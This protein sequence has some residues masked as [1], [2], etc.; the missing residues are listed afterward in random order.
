MFS[1][2]AD[3]YDLIYSS[4]DY[5]SEARKIREII[6]RCAPGAKSILDVGCGTGEHA[7]Y[8]S[9]PYQV[10]GL[11]LDSQFVDIAKRKVP[12]GD[13][14]VGDM[15]DFTFGKRYDVV[16]CLFSS[17]GYLLSGTEIL[18]A[19]KCFRNHLAA[20]GVVLVEPWILPQKFVSGRVG[21]ETADKPGLKICRMGV[22]VREGDV[23]SVHFHYLIADSKGIRHVEETHRLLLVTT[24]QMR[25]YFLTAGMDCEYDSEG[26][27]GR[28]LFIGRVAG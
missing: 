15:R 4:K 23:S 20:G 22:S 26:V 25:G 2:T 12:S 21:L 16:Q 11:D 24:E 28:G 14:R 27:D 18:A 5:A 19:L 1:A 10:D 17:I 13:F 8:L 7:K 3:L 6:S 9:P